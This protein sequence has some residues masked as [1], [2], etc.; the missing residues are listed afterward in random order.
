MIFV[1]LPSRSSEETGIFFEDCFKTRKLSETRL[2]KTGSIAKT[3]EMSAKSAMLFL[4]FSVNSVRNI[5]RRQF[6]SRTKIGFAQREQRN[7]EYNLTYFCCLCE[8]ELCGQQLSS[9]T[10]H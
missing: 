10:D 7:R 6:V 3:A 8:K 2:R 4:C 9:K 5:F 1:L